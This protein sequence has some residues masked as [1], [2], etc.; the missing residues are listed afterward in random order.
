MRAIFVCF[1][2]FS[3]GIGSLRAQTS[4]GPSPQRPVV[5]ATVIMHAIFGGEGS[6]TYHYVN[7]DEVRLVL[8]PEDPGRHYNYPEKIQV[9]R[10]DNWQFQ[11][12]GAG[13]IQVFER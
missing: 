4:E 10:L 13:Q 5:A 8:K 11:F 12:S 2:L 3:I 1:F 7:D 9:R 6:Y